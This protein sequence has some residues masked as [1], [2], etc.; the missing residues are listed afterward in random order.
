[1]NDEVIIG[2]ADFKVVSGNHKLVTIGLG[3]CIGVVIYDELKSVSGLGHFM[4]PN[5]K[6]A[7][8]SKPTKPNKYGDTLINGMVEKIVELG[9]RKYNLKAKAAGGASMF[10]N[11]SRNN[12]MNISKRNIQSL[13]YNLNLHGIPIVSK[14]VGGNKGRTIIFDTSTYMLSIKTV[15]TSL[16]RKNGYE[17]LEI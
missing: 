8:K 9:G 1:M 5:S 17:I 2:I 10:K 13:K 14:R 6:D 11:L 15:N 7:S 4:L 3:S 12:N 16:S